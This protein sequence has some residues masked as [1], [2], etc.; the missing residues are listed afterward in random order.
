MNDVTVRALTEDDW[1]TYRQM[2]LAGLKESPAAFVSTYQEEESFEEDFWRLRMRRSTRLLAE[3]DGV[4][5]G[6]ASTG[7]AKPIDEIDEARQNVAEI[8]GMWVDPESRG[9]GVAWRLVDAAAAE[10]HKQNRSHLMLWVV[11]DNGRAVA[12]Y[13][14]YGFRPSDSR[15]PVRTDASLT[16]MAMVLPVR[17]DPGAVPNSQAR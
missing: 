2:R 1:K 7:D 6:I 4:P 14:S 9:T 13:S 3:R 8:F 17:D 15:R 5:V 16:E 11:I 10:A 12:F